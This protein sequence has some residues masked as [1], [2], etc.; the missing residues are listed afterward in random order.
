MEFMG[1]LIQSLP[2]LD[3]YLFALQL[4]PLP[5]SDG[6][7]SERHYLSSVGKYTITI[8]SNDDEI[9]CHASAYSYL[10]PTLL[11]CCIVPVLAAPLLYTCICNVV[12]WLVS[13][14]EW[15]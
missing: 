8:M 12:T 14:A 11:H 5:V 6:A 9:D 2:T 15:M 1:Y 13:G 3:H 4:A 7:T 10:P